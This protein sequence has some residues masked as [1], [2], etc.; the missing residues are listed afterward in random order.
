M[1]YP[2]V[3]FL[4]DGVLLEKGGGGTVHLTDAPFGQVLPKTSINVYITVQLGADTGM[5]LMP[6]RRGEGC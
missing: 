5:R 4:E 6:G 1:I 3:V 2:G